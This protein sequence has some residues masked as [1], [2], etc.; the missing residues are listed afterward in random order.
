MISF[1]SSC[2]LT[3]PRFSKTTTGVTI[4]NTSSQIE[5]LKKEDYT[6]LRTTT[7]KASTTR[8]YILFIPI[9]KHKTNNELFDNA[10]YSAVENLP[11]ADALLLPHQKTKKLT[12]PLLLFNYNR[13][14]TTVTGV[15]ISIKDKVIENADLNVPYKELRNYT[16]KPGVNRKKIKEYK[17]TSAREFERYFERSAGQSNEMAERIDFSNQYAIVLIGKAT[18]KPTQYLINHLQLK[19]AQIELSFD[20]EEGEKQAEAQLPYAILV[21][22][23]EY[24][25]EIVLD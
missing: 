16:L 14:T 19:G 5:S 12:V 7:G 4:T 18:K 15:G 20:V 6:V 24:Q 8:C 22:N 25:G 21:V 11:N 10:Y 17:I 23:K 13:R 3:L 2:S 9:G 1:M